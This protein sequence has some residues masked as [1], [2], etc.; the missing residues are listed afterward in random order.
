M[1]SFFRQSRSESGLGLA[2]IQNN[3]SNRLKKKELQ[4]SL[5]I[6]GSLLLYMALPEINHSSFWSA[7]CSLDGRSIKDAYRAVEERLARE[8]SRM[9]SHHKP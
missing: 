2:S 7:K 1:S 3:K 4:K 6:S 5:E 9:P 8:D